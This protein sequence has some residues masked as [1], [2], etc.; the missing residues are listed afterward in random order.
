MDNLSV[1]SSVNKMS[2]SV[3][4]IFN[5]LRRRRN[6]IIH[7]RKEIEPAD[8]HYCLNISDRILRNRINT[9]NDP[10]LGI[11]NITANSLGSKTHYWCSSFRFS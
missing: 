2:E 6:D 9:P 8:A 11:D 10:F 1:L 4:D 3:R 5:Q 7:E